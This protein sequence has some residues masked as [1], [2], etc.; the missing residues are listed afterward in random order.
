MRCRGE[1]TFHDLGP[2]PVSHTVR[3]L[4]I[5]ATRLLRERRGISRYVRNVL[6]ELTQQQP[7]LRFTLFVQRTRDIAAMRDLLDGLH[8]GLGDWAAVEPIS[9]L[10]HTEADVIWHPWNQVLHANTRAANVVTIHDI[11]PMLQHDHRWWKIIKRAKYRRRYARSIARADGILTISQFTRDEVLERFPASA[12]KLSVTLLAA[13]DLA[14]SAPDDASALQRSDCDDG[15]F[16]SVGGQEARK[17]LSTLYAAMDRL[18]ARGV[19]VPLVQ[20]GPGLSKETRAIQGR[21]PW[22]RHIGY[23][24]DAQLVTLYRRTTALVFPSRYEGFGLPVLEAMRSGAPVVCSTA[25]SLPEVSGAAAL[26]VAWNDVEALT[27]AMHRIVDDAALR[28]DLRA[29][30]L[31]QASGFSWARTA[32]ET[33]D[34]MQRAVER[35]RAR[36][37]P[38]TWRSTVQPMTRP[39]VHAL[40]Q[41]TQTPRLSPL[42]HRTVVRTAT[43]LHEAPDR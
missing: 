2:A 22:L 21:A 39:I 30:G 11:A 18:W 6:R 3:H 9:A 23:V 19:R 12:E 29:R 5:E 27:R 16:L 31:V 17:N 20:C 36:S 43:R 10:A 24:T 13:D 32:S 26:S 25:S 34:A 7:H 38:R 41:M 33:F 35:H 28:D 14:L 8:T 15:F 4:A 1:E 40:A 37:S 42:A